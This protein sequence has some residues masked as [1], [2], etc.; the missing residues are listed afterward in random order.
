[1]LDY[2][3]VAITHSCGFLRYISVTFDFHLSTLQLHATFDVN[4]VCGRTLY[5]TTTTDHDV[6]ENSTQGIQNW[7]EFF[8]F[9]NSTSD[10]QLFFCIA[11]KHALLVIFF[12][13]FF[14]SFLIQFSTF[15]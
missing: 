15:E 12:L 14:L 6:H 3:A 1:M 8:L 11:S 4:I 10:P 5:F 7:L 13:P 2:V 9:Q